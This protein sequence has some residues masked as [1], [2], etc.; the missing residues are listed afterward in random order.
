MSK[1]T[2]LN[3]TSIATVAST[4]KDSS[5]GKGVTSAG[6]IVPK[7]VL[8][9]ASISIV[10]HIPIYLMTRVIDYGIQLGEDK[11]AK[12]YAKECIESFKKIKEKIDD[13]KKKEKIDIEIEKLE[14][15]LKRF[16][17]KKKSK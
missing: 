10:K 4:V 3:Y 2:I 16:D 1:S 14:K 15:E 11:V 9:W 5:P 17:N 12:S 6:N 7:M 8:T 13:P